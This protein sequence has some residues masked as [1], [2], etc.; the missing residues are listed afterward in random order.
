MRN[1]IFAIRL[2]ALAAL[3]LTLMPVP[4]GA[5]GPPDDPI[6]RLETGMHTARINR[7]GVNRAETILVTGSYDKTVRVWDLETGAL[8]KILRVPMDRGMDGRIYAVAVSPN[9]RTVVAGGWTGYAWDR[10]T[11]IYRFALPSGALKGRITGLPDVIIHLA[12]S[13]DGRYLA[14]TLGGENG[15]RVYKTEDWSLA[16][17]DTD[18]DGRSHWAD[19]DRTGR[20]VTTCFDGFIRLYDRS[21]GRIAR[22]KGLGGDRPFSAVFSP[23]GERVAVGYSDSTAVDLLSGD[24][25]THLFS[26]DTSGVDNR[27]VFIAAWSADGKR[28][29]AGGRWDEGG[30]RLIRQWDDYGQGPYRDM[31]G[32]LNTIM[33]I[34]PLSDGRTVFGSTDPAWGVLDRSGER[35]QFVEAEVADFRGKIEDTFKTSSKGTTVRFGFKYG[36]KRPARFSIQGRTLT[37]APDPTGLI[38]PTIQADGLTVTG[39]ENTYTPKL[40]GKLLN[41]KQYE[42]SRSLAIAPD[43]Q[44]FILGA[45]WY[46]R[47]FDED[48][49]LLWKVSVSGA[50]WGVNVSGDGKTAVAAIGDGTIRWYRMTD[51]EE[52]LALF[53]HKDGERWVLWTPS[54]YYAASTGGDELIGWHVNRGR[55]QTP[56][57][58]PAARFRA[59]KYR[60]DVVDRVLETHDEAEALRLADKAAG[61]RRQEIDIRQMLPPVVTLLAP[62]DGATFS[63]TGMTVRYSIRSPSDEPVTSVKV[64]VDGRPL[65]G[66]RSIKRNPDAESGTFQVTLPKKDCEIAVIAENRHAASEPATARLSW[67]GEPPR[68]D[69]FVIKP[70][71][72]V[73]AVG[74]GKYELEDL[75][76]DF[77]AKDARDFAGV[78][79]R[80]KG[81][82]YRDVRTTV[83]TDETAT[84]GDVLDGLDWIERETTDNDVAAIFLAG[85]GIN[86]RDGDYYFLPSNAD[87]DRLRRTG[88]PY[89]VIKDVVTGL[90][91][92][93]LFFIDTCHAGNV[94]GK[95]RGGPA[96]IIAVVNDLSAAENG[97]VVFASSTGEQYS[98]EDT[99]WRNGAFTKA[100]VEGLSG[101]ADYTKD[102]NISI[103]EMDLYLS[104]RVKKLTGGMQT[105]TTSKPDTVPDFPVAVR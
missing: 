47:R 59:V 17:E 82:L 76:L 41:L 99:R 52:L 4:A 24:D 51:G 80:Q 98:L 31:T 33:H 104:E 20:L 66:R 25:L 69:E 91:G 34:L 38:P 78:L 87:P 28:L 5:A 101:R 49:D 89:A 96:D 48:G 50:A 27:N 39:W 13:D 74:V 62:T 75:R 37:L 35:V 92:K 1:T 42:K 21:F 93:V 26:P 14:A 22:K 79:T 63:D 67:A 11:C 40:N 65:P 73:L 57:F 53:P 7:I 64:L 88:V 84:K 43:R 103:N 85:H 23:D 29:F 9:G 36:G 54:G 105:P 81:K 97:V 32:S 15:I 8:R 72:Y 44:S 30:I 68:T 60:P 61:R 16:G 100:L 58:F 10:K 56:D 86:D 71:L 46:V 55:D 18:Y 90:P 94:M 12:F 83:V 6:L 70:K 3:L 19:F 95:R 77:P 2:A 102:G 45:D